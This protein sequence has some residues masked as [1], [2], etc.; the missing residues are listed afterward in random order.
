M[1]TIG[2]KEAFYVRQVT[3]PALKTLSEMKEYI[4]G[5]TYGVLITKPA[6]AGM[7]EIKAA[8]MARNFIL[9]GDRAN[10]DVD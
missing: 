6:M 3:T 4:A 10:G 9:L 2:S 8:A 5:C 7:T 1:G